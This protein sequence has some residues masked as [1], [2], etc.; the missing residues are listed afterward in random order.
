MKKIFTAMINAFRAPSAEEMAV[1]ELA[2]AKR[3]L[4]EAESAREY[5]AAISYYNLERIARLKNYG[6]EIS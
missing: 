2:E 4:L 6:K 3:E 5:A 1:R